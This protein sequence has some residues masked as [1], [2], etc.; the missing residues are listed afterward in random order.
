MSGNV[1]LTGGKSNIVLVEQA[2][3]L[4]ADDGQVTVDTSTEASLQMDC[5]PA[6]PPTTLV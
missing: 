2:Q 1:A 4:L 6:T 5:A 3:I